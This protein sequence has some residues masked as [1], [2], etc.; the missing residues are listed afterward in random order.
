MKLILTDRQAEVLRAVIHNY[1]LEA[2]PVGSRLIAK[3]YGLGLSAATIRNVMADLEEFGYLTHPHTSAGRIPTSTGYSLYVNSLMEVEKLSNSVKQKIRANVD[4][5]LDKDVDFLLGKTSNILATVSKQLGVVIG[6]SLDNA[7]LEKIS[8][9][10][11]SSEKV[12]VILSLRNG[13][14]KS[15]V[16][17][18]K[19]NYNIKDLEITSQLLNAKLS[20]LTILKIK[21]SIGARL[22]EINLGNSEIIRLFVDSADKFFDF[23]KKKIFVGGT[24]NIM[25]NPEFSPNDKIKSIIELLEDQDVIIHLLNEA[26]NKSGIV[27]KIGDENNSDVANSFSIVSKQYSIGN[28]IGTLGVIGPARMWYPKMVPIVDYTADL[29]NKVLK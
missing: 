10:G 25:E 13:I 16:V 2:K 20:G 28:Q 5:T 15:I 4:N 6:P 7:I 9:V 1:I 8:L 12:M 3:K 27:I 24:K 18:I 14:I 29:I 17:E 23:D 11:V 22:K 19:A 26:K 21:T